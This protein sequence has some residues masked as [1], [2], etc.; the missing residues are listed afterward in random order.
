M[1]TKIVANPPISSRNSCSIQN[2]RVTRNPPLKHWHNDQVQK[3]TQPSACNVVIQDVAQTSSAPPLTLNVTSVKKLDTSPTSSWPKPPKLMNLTITLELTLMWMHLMYHQMTPFMSAM[4]K[5]PKNLLN[6]E[7]MP[8][9]KKAILTIISKHAFAQQLTLIWYQP[10]CTPK[11]LRIVKWNSLA[12]WT[13]TYLCT[14]TV[15]SKH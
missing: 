11:S 10:Q 9:L 6:R 4:S 8:I 15:L 5:C 1:A 7:Y 3:Q 14:M 2:R 13:L 12:L